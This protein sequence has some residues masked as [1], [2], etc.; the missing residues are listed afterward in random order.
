[1][2]A[3]QPKQTKLRQ[4]FQIKWTIAKLNLNHVWWRKVCK[5]W[6]D[7]SWMQSITQIPTRT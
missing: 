5:K 6:W 3:N 4:L 1:M 2:R 7:G